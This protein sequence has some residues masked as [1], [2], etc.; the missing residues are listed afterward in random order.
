MLGVGQD[1]GEGAAFDEPHVQVELV[2]DLAETVDGDD[3]RLVQAGGGLGLALEPFL[4]YGVFGEV[5]RQYLER[6]SA[7]GVGVISDVDLAHAAAAYQFAQLV[8]P[9]SCRLHPALLG[10]SVSCESYNTW[11]AVAW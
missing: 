4:E 10:V 8:V 5:R 3:V 9:E 11:S 6:D 2:V 1:L 7:L